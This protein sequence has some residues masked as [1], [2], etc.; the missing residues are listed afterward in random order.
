MFVKFK[1][2][3]DEEAEPQWLQEMLEDSK[4]RMLLIELAEK[5]KVDFDFSMNDL[6]C[7]R[8]VVC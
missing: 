2:V 1:H 8:R 4:W 5:H 7:R 3:L 6:I